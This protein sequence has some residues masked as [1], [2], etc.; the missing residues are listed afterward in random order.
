MFPW[1]RKR[2]EP[3]PIAAANP[4][5]GHQLQTA[6]TNGKRTWTESADVLASLATTLAELG[7]KFQTRSEWLELE[8]GLL[9]VPRFVEVAQREDSK[10]RT[11]ST[12]QIS[13]PKRIPEGVFEYQHSWGENVGRSFADGFKMW[14]Q[15][16][17]P[18]FLDATL[19]NIANRQCAMIQPRSEG[20]SLLPPHRRVIFG[21]TSHFAQQPAPG[22]EEHC[23]CPCCLFT[24]SADSFRGLAAQDAFFGIRLFAWRSEDGATIEA[25]CRVNGV[26]FP[27]GVAG[28]LRY[29]ETWPH[30]GMEFRK[31]Y[32]AIQ[33]FP[34]SG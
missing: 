3:P 19:E 2:P 31:Q 25:D 9:L 13:H 22:S 26:D 21:P 23:F 24:N 29:V 6:F 33:S 10:V 15:A 11:A 7:H 8:N 30:R 18:V 17:L 32:V 16:D 12:V 27:E 34:P 1:F 14:A 20:S 28:L 5:K 4:G